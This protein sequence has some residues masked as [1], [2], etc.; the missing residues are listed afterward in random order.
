MLIKQLSA[1]HE[2][3]A[4]A[5]LQTAVW[6]FS[7]ID[8]VP[9]YIF[10][11]AVRAGGL[12][13]GAYEE[14]KLVGYALGFRGYVDGQ[15]FMYSHLVGVHPNY[16]DGGVGYDLKMAQKKFALENELEKIV[17]TFNPMHSR[18][19]RLNIAKLGARVSRYIAPAKS[20]NA[21]EGF[22]TPR[23]EVTWDIQQSHKQ[24]DGWKRALRIAD[25]SE[26][27]F[28][29]LVPG[30][31]VAQEPILSLQVPLDFDSLLEKEPEK[32]Q[33]WQSMVM[34]YSDRLL[35]NGFVVSDY[36]CDDVSGHYLLERCENV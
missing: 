18:N 4:M 8:V 10:V 7:P 32:A 22:L 20:E 6:G 15:H 35:N 21:F 13:L 12:V 33:A 29:V 1:F 31:D 9:S 24:S 25:V 36:R 5:E 30:V 11:A 3:D 23:Y 28:P 16:R 2:L 26:S 19:A 27:N 14:D 34:D 17:W